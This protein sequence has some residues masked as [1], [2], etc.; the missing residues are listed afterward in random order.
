MIVRGRSQAVNIRR[1]VVKGSEEKDR[2]QLN[3]LLL[4]WLKN[5]KGMVLIIRLWVVVLIQIIRF[6]ENHVS[7]S[8]II[9]GMISFSIGVGL[10]YVRSLSRMC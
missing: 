6:L 9:V 8:N 5:S 3:R 10:G 2:E 7:G 4:I 1:G